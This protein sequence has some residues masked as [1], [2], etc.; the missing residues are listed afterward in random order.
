MVDLIETSCADFA[1]ALASDAP[2]PGGGSAAAL[3]GALSAA[4]GAMAARLSL[5]RKKTEEERAPLE[6]DVQ[7]AEALRQ[8]LLSLVDRD[9]A[10]FEPLS[11]AYSLPKEDPERE[12]K[13]RA[14][15]LAACAAPLELLRCCGETAELLAGLRERV[16]LM[17][18]SDVG[19]AAALCAV[20]AAVRERLEN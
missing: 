5:R 2:V 4:L 11:R 15:S 19:S 9:A 8:R 17:L 6:E 14:A 18:L 20:T 7:I 3:A 16:S 13:L 1:A 12:Q 10:G